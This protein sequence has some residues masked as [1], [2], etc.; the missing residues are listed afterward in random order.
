[1]RAGGLAWIGRKPPKLRNMD[2]SHYKN[3]LYKRY[4]HTWAVLVFAYSRKYC[5]CLENPR[6]LTMLSGTII[7]NVIK[8]LVTL[9]K[10]LGKYNEF[11]EKLNNYGIKCTR[12]DNLK[13]FLRIMN[14]NSSNILEYYKKTYHSLKDNEALYVKFLLLTGLR[15]TEGITAFNKIISL[16]KVAIASIPSQLSPFQ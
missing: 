2:W 10:Y 11:K 16:S 7:N 5:H 1:M 15:K 8:S 13:S 4:R 9:S 3:Y 6:E 14:N 12:Q